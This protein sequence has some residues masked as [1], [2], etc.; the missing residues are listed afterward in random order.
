MKIT[1]GAFLKSALFF[2][3]IISLSLYSPGCSRLPAEHT[4]V[5][6]KDGE[7]RLPL[8]E[9]NDGKV[10]FYTYKKSGKRINFFV[11]TDG[12]NNL[13]AYFDACFTCNKF[14]KGYRVEGTDLVCNECGLKFG[15]ADEKWDNSQGCSP[16]M[17][18][19]RI[20]S[21]YLV[22]RADDVEK[23]SRLF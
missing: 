16:I 9:V 22:I 15:I 21:G 8:N 10:H 1:T 3:I 5:T 4:R 18:R 19:S 7:T 6:A 11:R 20:D 23:G 17:L 13:S 14:K 12:N 2:S